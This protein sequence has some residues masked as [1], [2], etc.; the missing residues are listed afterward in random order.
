M[1]PDCF[2]AARLSAFAFL[3]EGVKRHPFME[4]SVIKDTVEHPTRHSGA[5]HRKNKK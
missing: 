5:R 2:A 1:V 4:R 3:R